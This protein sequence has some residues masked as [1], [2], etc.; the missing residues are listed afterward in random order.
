MGISQILFGKR[1]KDLN[2]EEFKQYRKLKSKE[3]YERKT[4]NVHK[5]QH[6]ICFQMLGKKVA[7][8]T[9]DEYKQYRRFTNKNY[10]LSKFQTNKHDMSICRRKYGKRAREFT[11]AEKR[12]YETIMRNKRKD[13]RLRQEA[14]DIV[15]KAESE[16]RFLTDAENK[17]LTKIE[18]MLNKVQYWHKGE[19]LIEF[20]EAK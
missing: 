8:L 13:C 1:Y 3:Y 20:G 16:Q 15:A 2:E 10:R 7:E 19:C 4:N 11:N 12:E 6:S 17:R 9:D 5:Q 14:N 18:K